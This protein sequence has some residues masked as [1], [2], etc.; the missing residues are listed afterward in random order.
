[1]SPGDSA[2]IVADVEVNSPTTFLVRES[3][4]PRWHAFID[5][6]EV[7]VR[8]MTPDF[9]AVDVPP[10]KH[11]ISMRF[12]RPWWVWA[13]WLVWPLTAIGAWLL[14]KQMA[15]RFPPSAAAAKSL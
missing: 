9:P 11:E 7:P 8:R 6:D 10:G 13:C 3:W 1:M 5:G 2:D 12:E 4:H 15:R 14:S